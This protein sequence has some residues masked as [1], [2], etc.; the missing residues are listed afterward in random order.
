MFDT[1][2]QMDVIRDLA[3][4]DVLYTSVVDFGGNIWTVFLFENFFPEADEDWEKFIASPSI[5]RF[6]EQLNK[7]FG[8][9]V[10][11]FSKGWYTARL[12]ADLPKTSSQEYK[13]LKKE[14]CKEFWMKD[15]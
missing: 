10:V 3:N 5:N 12:W 15:I 7:N 11:A 9:G 4:E 1:E 14:I 6:A 13:L 2:K 8:L